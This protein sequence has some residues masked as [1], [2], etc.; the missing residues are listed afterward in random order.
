MFGKLGDLTGLLKSAKQMQ[1]NMARL[2]QELASR[3]FE[4]H[5]GAGLVRATVDGRGTLIDVNIEPKAAEDIELLEDLVKAAVGSAVT[6]SQEA[7]RQ[8]MSA[9]TGGLNIP[10]LSDMFG[11]G[12]TPPATS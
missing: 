10:G 5:A 11:G 4:A 12:A 2:Q 7:M 3:R 6:K 8:E 9:M 1:E